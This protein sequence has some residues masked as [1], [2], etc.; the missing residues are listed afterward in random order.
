LL[1]L[2]DSLKQVNK[3]IFNSVHIEKEVYFFIMRQ[4]YDLE[5]GVSQND[6]KITQNGVYVVAEAGYD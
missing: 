4:N 1:E 3:S 2:H 6:K 5:A